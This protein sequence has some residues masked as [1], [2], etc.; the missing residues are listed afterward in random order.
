MNKSE[1][2]NNNSKLV[3][4]ATNAK[5]VAA[6]ITN[7][8]RKK[9][10]IRLEHFERK[11]VTCDDG[12][13]IVLEDHSI[14]NK[15][16]RALMGR[17]LVKRLSY[18]FLNM[19]LRRKREKWMD[20]KLILL[21]PNCFMCIFNRSETCDTVGSVAEA[22]FLYWNNNRVA[23]VASFIGELLWPDHQTE[24]DDLTANDTQ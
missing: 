6:I 22:S 24:G 18:H 8:W 17:L 7:L 21:V 9:E 13:T 20:F 3:N 15:L 1:A 4:G 2:S 14:E 16:E 23:R 12:A 10:F 19:D 11:D 5:V